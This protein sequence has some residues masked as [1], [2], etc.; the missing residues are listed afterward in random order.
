M[1]KLA[2][3][4][5]IIAT[6]TCCLAADPAVNDSLKSLQDD[7]LAGRCPAKAPSVVC[8][9]ADANYLGRIFYS[10][11]ADCTSRWQDSKDALQWNLDVEEDSVPSLRLLYACARGNGGSFEVQIGREKVLGHA[12][13]TRS[14]TDFQTMEIGPVKLAKGHYTLSVRG[15][16]IKGTLMNLRALTLAPLKG[17]GRTQPERLPPVFVVPNHHPASCGWLVNFSV[18]RNY[19]ANNYLLHLD[20]V[21]DDPNYCFALSECNNLIAIRDFQP[22]R[23]E[24]LKSRIAEGRVELVNGFFL[25]PDINLSGGE[26]LAKMGIEG[27]RWQQRVMGVRPRH[28]W[29]IDSCGVPNQMGQLCQQL[30]LE[31]LLY[32]RCNNT[33][34]NVFWTESPDGSRVLTLG[35]KSYANRMGGLFPAIGPLKPAATTGAQS[36]AS[37]VGG[38]SPEDNRPPTR[39]ML[40]YV[41]HDIGGM[42]P[43]TPAGLPMLVLAGRSD[44]SLP[45]ARP[46]KISEF[47]DA[48]KKYRPDVAMRFTGPSAYLDDVMAAIRSGTIELATQRDTVGYA[49]SAQWINAPKLKSWYRRDEHALQAAEILATAASFTD[50]Y[51]YPVQPLYHAWLQMLLNMDRNTIW[52][53]A[54]G[55]VFEDPAS[56]DAKDR[57]E[58]VEK[59]SGE[60][61]A[62]AARALAGTGSSISIF[63]PANWQRNDPVRL[64][65]PKGAGLAHLQAETDDD[66][67]VLCDAALPP[68]G[69]AGVELTANPVPPPKAIAVPHVI[70]T[71]VYAARIDPVTG[72]ITG[73]KCKPSGRELLGGS[74]GLI[75]AEKDSGRGHGNHMDPRP[76]RQR[77]KTSADFPATVTAT[78]GPVAITVTARSGFVGGGAM[79]RVIRFFKNHPRIEFETELND[80]PDCT[81]VVAE[82][83]LAEKAAEVRRGIPFGFSRDDLAGIK[84]IAPALRYIDYA[85]PGVGGLALLDRGLPGREQTANTAV[86]YLVNAVDKYAGY[87]PGWS[88]GKGRHRLEYALVPHAQDWAAARIP[89]LAWEYN[90]P[91]IAFSG[92]AMLPP[93]SI[94]TTSENLIL[95]TMRR[96]GPDLELRL[97]ETTGQAGTARVCLNLP[98]TAA[99]LTDLV[100]GRR[101]PL[102]GGPAYQFPVKPMQILT[103]RC[104]TA[105]AVADIQPLLTWDELVPP[106]KRAALHRYDP[107]LLGHPPVGAEMTTDQGDQSKAAVVRPATTGSATDQGNQSN[108][109]VLHPATSQ[110]NQK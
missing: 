99:A 104:R 9:A 74:A 46:E 44:Y 75:V 108:S 54:R 41:E 7:S 53:N 39:Q 72:A 16:E 4:I 32:V 64:R 12:M 47:L 88:S 8:T 103:L 68:V 67:S 97:A 76:A 33:G 83:P 21:R 48:W 29:M 51:E 71:A 109:A 36:Y 22:R 89:Q 84:G 23:F 26:A 60:T 73:L 95:E 59:C 80:I 50:R 17:S 102:S 101:Q 61:L 69:T 19:C 91:P 58:W 30:G 14:G 98:H 25:E 38:L 90:S 35:V 49:Y 20:A 1:R 62:G 106:A 43:Q 81:V 77:W 6:A 11:E 45:P 70:E 79:Q 65:L 40:W 5:L 82:F 24:E 52:S 34:K 27:L 56:W 92:C 37:R 96:D 42:V 10:A 63:N 78:E 100:G 18:E 57:F 85:T 93:K 86:L 3:L 110:K 28:C 105:E 107:T 15:L 31:T 13:P 2:S 55:T 94:L 87:D 66:G